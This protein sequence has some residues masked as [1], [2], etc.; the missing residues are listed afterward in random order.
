MLRDRVL[1]GAGIGA[2]L[3]GIGAFVGTPK[4]ARSKLIGL[5]IGGRELTV[6]PIRDPNIGWIIL[7]RALLHHRLVAERNHARREALII[8]AGAENRL[9]EQISAADRRAV[10][11]LLVAIGERGA[12]EVSEREALEDLIGSL[13][14]PRKEP[15]KAHE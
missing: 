8:D 4:L 10:D 7:T 9:S 6:G 5:P 12:A 11:R 1:D 2:L 14:D 3:G 15:G 13:L